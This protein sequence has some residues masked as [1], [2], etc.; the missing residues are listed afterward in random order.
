MY[1]CL[2]S[3]NNSKPE[4]SDPKVMTIY[5]YTTHVE[6]QFKIKQTNRFT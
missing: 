5:L 3:G 1:S 4:F 6:Q 2:R